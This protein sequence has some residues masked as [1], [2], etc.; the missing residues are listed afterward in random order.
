M[1]RRPVHEGSPF[2]LPKPGSLLPRASINLIHE[3]IMRKV[4]LC[5]FFL[6]CPILWNLLLFLKADSSFVVSYPDTKKRE[7]VHQVF[8][9]F[10]DEMS[11]SWAE[12]SKSWH[13][14]PYTQW[15]KTECISAIQTVMPD[16]R[17]LLDYK[18]VQ[19]GDVCRVAIIYLHGGVYADMDICAQEFT[20]F[21]K[22]EACFVKTSLGLSNDFF[23]ARKGHPL[24]LRI[25]ES[26]ANARW[27]DSPLYLPYIR[28]MFTTG[29]VRFSL[30]VQGYPGVRTVTYASMSLKHIK[31]SSWH[32]WD[33]PIFMRPQTFFL[34]CIIC[35]ALRTRIHSRCVSVSKLRCPAPCRRLSLY[36]FFSKRNV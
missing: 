9:L 14:F 6:Y 30:A 29:P 23:S 21:P 19:L 10:G 3:V 24:L 35:A 1:W 8:G 7:H 13:A 34:F 28:T 22:C 11:R 5:L 27:L 33:S 36:S 20:R 15:N 18:G 2:G 16:R 25:L 32:S 17:E 31:G 4:G 12:C 26:Y